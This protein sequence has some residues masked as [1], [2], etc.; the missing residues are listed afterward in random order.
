MGG[1]IICCSA[2]AS[3]YGSHGRF[4]ATPVVAQDLVHQPISPTFGGQNPFNFEPRPWVSRN[5]NND[6][7]TRARPRPISR[8]I[9]FR[10]NFSRGH[11]LGAVIAGRRMPSFVRTIR[12][13]NRHYQL[14]W[15]DHRILPLP[16]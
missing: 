16:G 13:G 14:R 3:L 6:T 2:K 12:L 9:F 11:A 5:A 8:P 15:P 1:G 4:V 10:G 7:A